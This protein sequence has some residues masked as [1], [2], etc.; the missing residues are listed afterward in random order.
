VEVTYKCWKCNKVG[1]TN[2]HVIAGCSSVS[3]SAYL[4]RKKHM[5]K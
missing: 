2:E 5:E 4:R 1:D 3:E